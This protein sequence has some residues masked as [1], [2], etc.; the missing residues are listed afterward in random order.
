MQKCSEHEKPAAAAS[1]SEVVKY[2]IS[3]QMGT[4][5]T[6][7]HILTASTPFF[8]VKFARDS[9]FL[10]AAYRIRQVVDNVGWKI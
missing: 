6:A 7:S 4:A 5:G 9:L 8:V 10:G 2:L 1:G 3:K